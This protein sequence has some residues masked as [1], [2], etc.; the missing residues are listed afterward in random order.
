[1][2]I[3]FVITFSNCGLTLQA[4]ATSDGISLFG[5][6][7][8]G[9]NNL[10]YKAYFLDENG[11]EKDEM[12]ADVNGDMTLV[13][14]L[15]PKEVGYLKNGTIR[16]VTDEGEPNFEFKEILNLSSNS[17]EKE[18]SLEQIVQLDQTLLQTE[19]IL[20]T[21]LPEVEIS[22]PTSE[23][24]NIIQ[25]NTVSNE[26]TISNET[27]N[28]VTNTSNVEETE[29][30]TVIDN[31]NTVTSD[32]TNV[33][34][35]EPA[36]GQAA[37]NDIPTEGQAV[38]NQEQE[39]VLVD[40]EKVYQDEAKE[41]EAND[42]IP[43][44]AI[45]T[46]INNE[47]E[48]L[49]ENVAESTK[50]Y[51]KLGYKAGETLNVSDLYKNV[52][53]DLIGTYINEDLEEIEISSTD[54]ITTEWTYSKD[55]LVSTEI[56]KVSPFEVEGTKGTLVESKI[57]V[58][59][60]CTEEN[61]LPLKETVIEFEA[62][63]INGK[64][65]IA[66]DVRATKL[67]A[68]VGEEIN[69]ITFSSDNWTY[70]SDKNTI[71]IKVENPNAILT[72]GE[73]IYVIVYRYD[74]Y[75]ESQEIT[76]DLKGTVSVEEYSGRENNRITKDFSGEKKTIVNI[77]ELITYSIGTTEDLISKGKINANYNSVEAVYDTEFTSTVSINIL[78]NDV[79][80]EFTLK[81]TKEYYIDKTN[82]EFEAQDVLYKAVKFKYAEIAE[83]L[84][85]GGTIEVR[86][87]TGEI[88]HTLNS[89][90]INS[91]E[92]CELVLNG[93]IHGV[94]ISVKDIKVNGTITV[95]FIKSIGKCTYEKAIFNNF[96]KIESR[97]KAQ[98]KYGTSDE[99]IELTPLKT[100]KYFE[101][102]YTRA[103]ISMNT[104]QL[105]TIA[106]NENV[107]L[108]IELNNNTDKSDLYINPEFEVV[109]PSYVTDVEV[110]SINLLYE[111]GLTV[112]NISLFKDA[113]NIQRMK[114]QLEGVQREFSASEITNGTNIIV[115]T[116]IVVDDYTPKKDDQLKMYYFNQGVTNYQSQTDWKISSAIPDGIIK[117]TNGFDVEVFSFQAPSGFITA[118]GIENYDGMGS[119]IETIKQGEV[120]AKAEMGTLTRDVTMTLAALNN[121]GNDCT[122]V[123]MLGRVPNTEATDVITGAKVGTNRDTHMV[124][125]ILQSDIN[126][127][128]C[129]IYYSYNPKADI[130][131]SN[132]ANGWTKT[133]EDMTQ[134]KS[135]LIVPTSTVK[136]GTLFKFSYNFQVPANLPYEVE[137]YGSFG[138]YYNN[139]TD[140]AVVYES[141]KADLV[142]LV[143]E[144]GPKIEAN[145]S[146][147][148]GDGADILSEKRMKYIITVVNSGSIDI[149][150]INVKAPIPEY[151]TYTVKDG[152]CYVGD[153]SFILDATKKE[154]EFNI[155]ILKAG[156]TKTFDYYVRTNRKPTLESYATGQDEKGYY[157]EEITGYKEVEIPPQ[158]D[159]EDVKYENE[160]KVVTQEPIIEKK[161]ITEVPDIYI[162]NKA[163]ISTETLAN[164]IETNETK[165]KLQYANFDTNITLD[166]DR[167]LAPGTPTNFTLNVQ[168]IS[169]RDLKNVEA[170]FN[171]GT[172]YEFS[173]GK[174]NDAD[175]DITFSSSDGKIYFKIPEMKKGETTVITTEVIAKKISKVKEEYNCQFQIKSEDMANYE[176]S[177][178]V[179]QSVIRGM[180][181]AKD[182]TINPLSQIKENETI[183][184]ST[185]VTNTGLSNVTTGKF[186]CDV[187]NNMDVR[188]IK[189][190]DGSTL[191]TGDGTGKIDAK[192]PIIKANESITIDMTLKAKNMSGVDTIKVILNRKITVADQ[193]DINIDPFEFTVLNTEKTDEEKEQE[194]IDELNKK[195]EEEKKQQEQEENNNNDNNIDNDNNNGN[196]T[197]EP[198]NNNNNIQPNT[199]TPNEPNVPTQPNENNTPNEPVEVPKYSIKGM[200]WLDEN[201]NGA[202]EDGEKALSSVKVYLLTV[203]H[204]MIKSTTTDNSGRYIFNDVENGKYIVAFVYDNKLYTTTV[205]KKA[206]VGEDRNSDVIE[207]NSDDMNAISNTITIENANI[208]NIDIGL[209]TKDT[210]DLQIT[211]YLSK[212]SVTTKKGTKEY[213]Y[214][215]VDLAKIDI[216][217]KQLKGAKVELE[218]T[219]T[220]ENKGSLEGYAEQVVD[221]IGTDIE[222]DEN[223]NKD[224]YKGNDGYIYMKNI[225]QTTLNPGQKKEYKISL[226][227]TM[228]TENTGTIS[229][230]VEIL[231]ALSNSAE[232]EKADNNTSVQNTIITIS[233]GRTLTNAI[234]IIFIIGVLA[235]LGYNK[236]LP[237]DIHFNK[238][239]KAKDKKISLKKFYK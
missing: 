158:A 103:E 137:M 96:E 17:K 109:F 40:E 74:E 157:I 73:D 78:T 46:K 233:T 206:D 57:V 236:R 125:G 65:P 150:N 13:L 87:N 23:S 153:H 43:V 231:K 180:I 66:L 101:K 227:K 143:T 119:T 237:I 136:A 70:N 3:V 165:N 12:Q 120:T 173:S 1:M 44:S 202:R 208:E 131:L 71:T 185:I 19:Q 154:M 91:Q 22:L 224:W 15:E 211:K 222:F 33:Q 161:Y 184:I 235:G 92:N 56:T 42:F 85:Q 147:D 183:V 190:S 166:Y 223:Q 100:E 31:T 29:N 146:V 156:E 212:A 126:P 77:G 189:C 140:L 55:I 219:I 127:I 82:L 197:Q 200:A 205:Y 84:N 163:T 196:Q 234:I 194:R 26:P 188:E 215:N 141:T 135:Y 94:E 149:Q 111:E 32:N 116:K 229:N 16:A 54:R 95:D 218:Y 170:I 152:R 124:S 210:F 178:P 4:L 115:N 27:V 214:N 14:E 117:T 38:D 123:S 102:S 216:H 67:K 226:T 98:V 28:E 39:D 9:K 238:V 53:L 171:V 167:V 133:P 195:Y 52:N 36:D 30:T 138:A 97:V 20:N 10:S 151:T 47:N 155:P 228:T 83:I 48:I 41:K 112:K 81:D 118:N 204:S 113:N 239:Y 160:E 35:A 159:S 45:S 232:E 2:A 60:D 209:Q 192:L 80:K 62:P 6:S 179:N 110:K 201:K 169:G 175:G 104:T 198:N 49:V 90:L 86:S 18:D 230:K 106:D 186:Q 68:T 108:K 144:A 177:T 139:H 50:I 132:G 76:V 89:N 176:Y 187:P 164:T 69:E 5:F 148:I 105:S 129:D 99:V 130:S 121:T 182:S 207:S 63:V 213:N 7:L 191:S 11:K 107:E 72:S 64:S 128:G 162:T 93:D 181:D 88:L 225:N 8:F 142:G 220:L 145:L 75:V 79:L 134:V 114:I 174:I 51:V 61:Y 21:D 203:G 37:E 34:D 221:Y 168:N 199:P 217:S 24:E 122:D 193:E 59:R 172:I 25:E 58:N